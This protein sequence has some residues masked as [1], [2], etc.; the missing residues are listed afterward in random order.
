MANSSTQGD[1]DRGIS[2]IRRSKRKSMTTSS[3]HWRHMCWKT[4]KWTNI[5]FWGM[6]PQRMN[7]E[8]RACI[9]ICVARFVMSRKSSQTCRALIVYRQTI[10]IPNFQNF[11]TARISEILSLWNAES[12]FVNIY[13]Y[14]LFEIHI[15]CRPRRAEDYCNLRTIEMILDSSVTWDLSRMTGQYEMRSSIQSVDT[16]RLTAGVDDSHTHHFPI[17]GH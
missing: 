14:W 7:C 8:G 4:T 6:Y 17:I 11:S 16:L 10:R 12:G 15:V 9:G 3:G 5:T 13:K 2:R 1:T